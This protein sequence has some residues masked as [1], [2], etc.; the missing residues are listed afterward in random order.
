MTCT[1]TQLCARLEPAAPTLTECQRPPVIET[2]DRM[3][4]NRIAYSGAGIKTVRRIAK[5]ALN[6]E[7]VR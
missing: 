1:H 6:G 2:V 5:A 7:L 4:L 3:A